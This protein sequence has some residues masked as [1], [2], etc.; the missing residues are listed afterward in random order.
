MFNDTLAESFMQSLRTKKRR[1]KK[2]MTITPLNMEEFQVAIRQ[3][4]VVDLT[5]L[6]R[7]YDWLGDTLSTKAHQISFI[8][9]H[10]RDSPKFWLDVV[11]HGDEEC[12]YELYLDLSPFFKD[13]ETKKSKMNRLR[14]VFIPDNYELGDRVL[15]EFDGADPANAAMGIKTDSFRDTARWVADD[16]DKLLKLG[17]Y[18]QAKYVEPMLTGVLVACGVR[19]CKFT[20]TGIKFNY[21]KQG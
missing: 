19:S 3:D 9:E 6:V 4:G 20:A 13:S 11:K 14:E 21:N 8:A 17:E 7:L 15:A 10:H 5:S 16:R 1:Y 12:R 2:G 18:I